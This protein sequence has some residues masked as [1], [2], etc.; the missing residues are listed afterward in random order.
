MM[1][2][3]N[4]LPGVPEQSERNDNRKFTAREDDGS[5]LYYYRARYYH[6]A[7]GRF[8]SEDPLEFVDGFN[9]Y[10]YTLNAPTNYRDSLG[11][12]SVVFWFWDNDFNPWTGGG[13]VDTALKMDREEYPGHRDPFGGD[14]HHCVASCLLARKYGALGGAIPIWWWNHY[15]ENDPDDMSANWRGYRQGI[16]IWMSCR[17]ACKGCNRR[18][19][20]P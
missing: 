15:N 14:Y 19:I 13:V 11:L 18:P 2:D 7:L 8:V 16:R 17:D 20:G 4:N 6:P 3:L 12:F 5:G 9:I 10:A 1:L